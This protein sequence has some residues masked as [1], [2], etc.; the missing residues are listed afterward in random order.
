[1][2]IIFNMVAFFS[3][4]NGPGPGETQQETQKSDL[5]LITLERNSYNFLESAFSWIQ[6]QGPI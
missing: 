1:M 4:G 2:S 3:V 6:E 5:N